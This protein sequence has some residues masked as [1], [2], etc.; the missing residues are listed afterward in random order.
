MQSCMKGH[1]ALIER[2]KSKCKWDSLS[3]R[4]MKEAVK[5]ERGV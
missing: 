1:A 5:F 4:Q 2:V 3:L